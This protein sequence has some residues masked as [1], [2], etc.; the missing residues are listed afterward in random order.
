LN[1][2]FTLANLAF[3]C[4]SIPLELLILF[5][6]GHELQGMSQRNLRI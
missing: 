1:L 6:Y 4:Q 3:N 2:L 5:L